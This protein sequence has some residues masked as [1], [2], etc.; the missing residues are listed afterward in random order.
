MGTHVLPTLWTGASARVDSLN[1]SEYL[2]RGGWTDRA[3]SCLTLRKER[4]LI[5]SCLGSDPV[6]EALNLKR[7]R[8]SSVC[9]VALFKPIRSSGS[10][11][12]DMVG[13]DTPVEQLIAEWSDD[14]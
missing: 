8:E 4:V 2:D 14:T 6:R 10:D 12:L 5:A 7:I 1:R 13:D 11:G 3:P 9:P